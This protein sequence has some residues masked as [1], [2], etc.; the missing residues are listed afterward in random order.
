M[1]QLAKGEFE[2]LMF[3]VGTSSWGGIRKLPYVFTEQGVAMLSSV[4]RSKRAICV[5]IQSAKSQK[6]EPGVSGICSSTIVQSQHIR[7]VHTGFK[8]C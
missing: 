8:L 3:L 6:I 5:N 7:I 2:S 4:L 1:F